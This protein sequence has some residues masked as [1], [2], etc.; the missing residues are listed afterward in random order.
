MKLTPVTVGIDEVGRGALA[1]PL[2]VGAAAILD[3]TVIERLP[4]VRDSK[5]LSKKQR[6]AVVTA[7]QQEPGVV[8][9]I[10]EVEAGEIDFFG[11]PAA[12][13]L[14][15]ERALAALKRQGF[16]PEKILA[17]AGLHHPFEDRVPTEHFI[18]GDTKIPEI[19]LAAI[20]AKVARDRHMAGLAAE[21]PEYRWEM[22]AG[23]GTRQHI[24][25]LQ[26][27]GMTDQHRSSFR[28]KTTE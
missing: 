9:G 18:K 23:Y 24:A 5:A 26:Q 8:I 7:L 13:R 22:N 16:W 14:A 25:V 20:V 17:D 28:L 3:P 27:E 15:S 6:E 1:G 4:V 21:Y 11:L 2:F 19:M 10:G 12:L